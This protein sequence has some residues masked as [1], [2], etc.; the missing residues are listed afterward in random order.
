M[1]LCIYYVVH[2]LNEPIAGGNRSAKVAAYV[3]LAQLGRAVKPKGRWDSSPREKM[4]LVTDQ[5]G[6][7]KA[8]WD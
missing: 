3:Q 1:N 4:L 5:A 7:S 6:G 2:L 8:Q